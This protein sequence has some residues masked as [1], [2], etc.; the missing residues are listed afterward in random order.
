MA[1]PYTKVYTS[2]RL[3]IG[4]G[5]LDDVFESAEN[6]IPG[7]DEIVMTTEYQV[8]YEESHETQ[9]SLSEKGLQRPELWNH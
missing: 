2:R 9:I 1:P 6:I 8:E 3:G 4:K 7:K 5:T